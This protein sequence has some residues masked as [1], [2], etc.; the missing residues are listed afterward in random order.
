M[1]LAA[2]AARVSMIAQAPNNH[3]PRLPIS[4]AHG[5]HRARLSCG[6]SPFRPVEKIENKGDD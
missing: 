4:A 5:V 2:T 3:F 6:N 1:A